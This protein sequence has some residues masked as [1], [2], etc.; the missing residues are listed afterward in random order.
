MR[1]V[2]TGTGLGILFKMTLLLLPVFFS[3]KIISLNKDLCIVIISCFL[4]FIALSLGLTYFI[5]DRIQYLFFFAYILSPYVLLTLIQIDNLKPII[6]L[7]MSVIF[8]CVFVLFQK[9]I[10]ANQSTFCFGHRVSPYVSIFNKTSDMSLE[11]NDPSCR[12]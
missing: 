2:E 7:I 4:A 5:F 11:Y 8:F 10:I 3:K 12:I 9:D 6:K 1:V